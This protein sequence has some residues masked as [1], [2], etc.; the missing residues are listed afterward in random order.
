MADGGWIKIHRS[1]FEWEW[2]SDAIMVKA[3]ISFLM[4][5]NTVPDFKWRGITLQPGQFV[6]TLADL[7]DRLNLSIRQTR[8]VLTRLE[9]TGEITIQT[10]NR[11]SIITVCKWES[12]Q[13][14]KID[15]L[16]TLQIQDVKSEI[17][18]DATN[19]RQTNDKQTT[20]NDRN[21]KESTKEKEKTLDK[22]E[23][24]NTPSNLPSDDLFGDVTSE[25][26]KPSCL[27]F[28]EFWNLYGKKV[29]RKTAERVYAKVSEKDRQLIKQH[30]P[31][32]VRSTPE[33]QYRKHP[34]TYLRGQCWNDEIITDGQRPLIDRTKKG[35]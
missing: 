6:T 15:K 14:E 34:T 4:L 10:T 28:D 11:Y 2:Y 25:P 9:E 30:L 16:E 19:K 21:E 33:V 24:L 31:L 7:S 18:S 5:C 27:P 20:N 8:T 12:Y 13:I 1:I 35:F 17:S 23:S 32:Y 26:P 3:F 22:K 29:D